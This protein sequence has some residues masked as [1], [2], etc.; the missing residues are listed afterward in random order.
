MGKKDVDA[1]MEEEDEEETVV[2]LSPIAKPLAKDKLVKKI[3][4]LVKAGLYWMPSAS[5]CPLAKLAFCFR[6]VCTC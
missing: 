5:P 2:V 6:C 4:K 1:S 3:L